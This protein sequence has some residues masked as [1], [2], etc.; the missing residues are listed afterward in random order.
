LL[1]LQLLLLEKQPPLTSKQELG[2]TAFS[3]CLPQHRELET[4]LTEYHPV[5]YVITL[6][7]T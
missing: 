2:I 3:C 5:H 7:S 4:D 6:H 1:Q